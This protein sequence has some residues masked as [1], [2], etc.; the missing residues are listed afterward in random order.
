MK[1]AIETFK[2]Y[3]KR[4]KLTDGL[5][6]GLREKMRGPDRE[7]DVDW[8]KLAEGGIAYKLR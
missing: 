4:D 5:T 3:A 7:T 8:E 2:K 1:R 6:E